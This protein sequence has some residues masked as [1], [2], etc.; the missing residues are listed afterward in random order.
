MP[1]TH[2]PHR[3]RRLLPALAAL[4]LAAGALTGCSADAA[5]ITAP[6]L[7]QA[8][9]GGSVRPSGTTQGSAGMGPRSGGTPGKPGAG[10]SGFLLSTGR[11]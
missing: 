7:N 8:Q 6:N 2:I 1:R 4:T 3:A 10:R 9:L 11:R 5:S